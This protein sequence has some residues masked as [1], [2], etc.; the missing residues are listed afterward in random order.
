MVQRVKE[1][2]SVVATFFCLAKITVV[3]LSD[4]LP[5]PILKA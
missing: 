2:C 5:G 1:V 3:K 4:D